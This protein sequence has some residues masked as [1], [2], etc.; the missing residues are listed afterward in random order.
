MPNDISAVPATEDSGLREEL[1]IIFILEGM[2][3]IQEILKCP[4]KIDN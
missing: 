2:V 4:N 3:A 1:Q